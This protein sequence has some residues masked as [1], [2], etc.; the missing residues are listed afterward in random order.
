MGDG[1]T[2]LTT[3]NVGVFHEDYSIH[4]YYRK[5]DDFGSEWAIYKLVDHSVSGCPFQIDCTY[6]GNEDMLYNFVGKWHQ[7]WKKIILLYPFIP[8][9]QI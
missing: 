4:R 6:N 3:E 8:D 2:E 1:F 7:V 5:Y 9:C